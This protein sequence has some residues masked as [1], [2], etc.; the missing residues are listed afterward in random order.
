MRTPIA[1]LV[2]A[3]N[4]ARERNPLSVVALDLPSGLDA[5]SGAPARPTV[6]ADVTVTFAAWKAGFDSPEAQPWLGRVVLKSIGIPTELLD[7]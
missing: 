7:R 1:R 6:R 5:D 2:D 3:V 4:T